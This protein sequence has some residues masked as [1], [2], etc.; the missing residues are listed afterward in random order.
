MMWNEITFCPKIGY[1]YY[2]FLTWKLILI[3]ILFAA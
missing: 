3:L 2:T 1:L